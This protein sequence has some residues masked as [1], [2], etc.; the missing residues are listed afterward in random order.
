M[1]ANH[2]LSGN[3]LCALGARSAFGKRECEPYRAKQDSAAK[4][5]AAARATVRRDHCGRGAEK[6]P[7]DRD[8]DQVDQEVATSNSSDLPVGVIARPHPT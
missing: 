1:R 4:P 5:K 6:Q 2:G 3:P 7:N 8:V